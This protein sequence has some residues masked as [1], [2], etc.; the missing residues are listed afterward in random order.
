MDMNQFYVQLPM[1][2][3]GDYGDVV[4]QSGKYDIICQKGYRRLLLLAAGGAV[5][6]QDV[7]LS[8]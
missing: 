3:T 5:E 4:V 2:V 7:T 1:T 6:N 8:V